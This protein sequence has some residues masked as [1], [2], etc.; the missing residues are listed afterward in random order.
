V[1]RSLTALALVATGLVAAPPPA[2]AV[3]TCG[4]KAATMVFGDGDDVVTGT[5]G[6]DVVVLGGGDDVYQDDNGGDDTIC[7]GPGNDTV[8][9]GYTSVVEGG[10]GRDE[11]KSEIGSPQLFGGPGDDHLQI[12]LSTPSAD[13]GAGTDSVSFWFGAQP[14][15]VDLA[16]ETASSP[17][18]GS[19]RLVRVEDVEGTAYAD[20]IRGDSAR[21]V[22]RG[23]DGDDRI[24]GRGG[25]DRAEGGSGR[26]TCAA[27]VQVSC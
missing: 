12:G 8:I 6:D 15:R 11:L 22:L 7:A 3:P 4:G 21:N 26:D 14:V 16:R 2:H 1:R 5:N 17:G 13:G 27:E 18:A 10:P 19:M 24:S 25:R 23:L 20:V 9:A